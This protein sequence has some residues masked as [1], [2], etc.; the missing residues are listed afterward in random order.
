MKKSI[1]AMLAVMLAGAIGVYFYLGGLNT[2]EVTVENVS[3]YNI[4]GVKFKGNGDSD[5]LRDAFFDAREYVE[6]G[7][8]A[9]VLTLIHYKDTTL[10]DEQVNVFVGIK[11]D[12]G[13]SDLPAGYQRLTIPARR[14]VRATIEAHNSVMPNSETV[15][16]RMLEKAEELRFE[17][18]DFTIEQYVSERIILIDM[19][20][21]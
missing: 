13:T 1:I 15:E 4:V 12:Q 18:S 9:G 11:L 19:P 8:V 2:V 14:T 6:Q 20:V 17:L 5:T 16:Q 3:D 10:T 7:R 21:R